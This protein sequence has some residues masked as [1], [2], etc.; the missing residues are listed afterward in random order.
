MS[1]TK[2]LLLGD[3]SFILEAESNYSLSFADTLYSQPDIKA[4]NA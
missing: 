1:M 4:V 2:T 3:V